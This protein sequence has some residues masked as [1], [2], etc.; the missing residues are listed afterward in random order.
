MNT[1]AASSDNEYAL[2][3]YF[4]EAEWGSPDLT[5]QNIHDADMVLLDSELSGALLSLLTR[6]ED[7]LWKGGKYKHEIITFG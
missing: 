2:P 6:S 1:N 4:I 3:D 5:Y 7:S